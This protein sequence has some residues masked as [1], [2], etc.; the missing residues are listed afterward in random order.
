[1]IDHGRIRQLGTPQEIYDDP[2]DTFVATFLGS[3]PMNL[4]GRNGRTVG[5]RPEHFYPRVLAGSDDDVAPFTFTA[6][7]EEYLGAER[8]VYGE[9]EGTR[10]IARFPVSMETPVELGRTHEFV[11]RRRDLRVFDSQTGQRLREPA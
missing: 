3:P 8:L 6:A 10:A 5:F 11:V 2:A 4:V 1:V 9:V 7:R